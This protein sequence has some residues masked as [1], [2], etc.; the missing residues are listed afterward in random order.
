MFLCFFSLTSSMTAN[1]FES[2]KEIGVLRAIGFTKN[3]IYFL[4]SYEAF[5]LVLASSMQGILIGIFVG[6]TM[7]VQ[8][9]IFANLPLTF[10]FPTV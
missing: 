9:Q 1:L 7:T 4:Y 5:I 6:W 2:A 8:Q 10:Y 3:R